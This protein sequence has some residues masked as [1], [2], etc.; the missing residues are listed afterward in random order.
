MYFDIDWYVIY[1]CTY[2]FPKWRA[3][4]EAKFY[5]LK[6]NLKISLWYWPHCPLI[7]ANLFLI[8]NHF[9]YQ[10]YAQNLHDII[11]GNHSQHNGAKPNPF[12]KFHIIYLSESDSIYI[13]DTSK[14]NSMIYKIILGTSNPPKFVWG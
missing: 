2:L 5:G 13:L 11:V 7:N 10:T 9:C 12:Y 8:M 1:C 6:Q 14:V 4:M 3:A